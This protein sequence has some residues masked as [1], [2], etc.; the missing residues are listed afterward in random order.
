MIV[1]MMAAADLHGVIGKDNALPW[2]LP[3]DMKRFRQHTSGKPVIMG[4]TTWRALGEKPL[5]KR[6]NIVLTHDA[7]RVQAQENVV[8]VGSLDDAFAA[9]GDVVEAVVIGGAVVYAA[10]IA[11]ADRVLITVVVGSFVGDARFPAIGDG[12]VYDTTTS[13][14][15]IERDDKNAFDTRYFDLWRPAAAQAPAT[16]K[17]FLWNRDTGDVRW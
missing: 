8:V 10:A 16:T 5:P 1:S 2:H 7:S 17:P 12:W 14:P 3:T 4:R 15:L 9:A 13:L 11:R 6:K